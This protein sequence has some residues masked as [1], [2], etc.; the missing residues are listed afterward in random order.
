VHFWESGPLSQEWHYF[1][2]SGTTFGKVAPL[3]GK[4]S[5]FPKVHHFSKSGATFPKWCQKSGGVKKKVVVKK[6]SV[7]KW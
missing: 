1:P 4:W 6:K 7:K 3:F 2:K 5:T